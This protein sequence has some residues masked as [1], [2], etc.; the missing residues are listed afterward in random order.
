MF[1]RKLISLLGMIALLCGA[2]AFEAQAETK[3]PEIMIGKPIEF[4][5]WMM[6]CSDPLYII[7]IIQVQVE[8]GREAFST[9]FWEYND[10]FKTEGWW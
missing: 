3:Q 10:F 9:A 6:S 4:N 7:D 2:V 1:F 8:H 5:A